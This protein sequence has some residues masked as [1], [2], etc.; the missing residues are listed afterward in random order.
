MTKEEELRVK[1]DRLSDTVMCLLAIIEEKQSEINDL[2]E[3][4]RQ[5]SAQL[6][7]GVV[8]ASPN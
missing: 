3:K 1:R 8:N 6:R 2:T 4:I 7:M 5:E